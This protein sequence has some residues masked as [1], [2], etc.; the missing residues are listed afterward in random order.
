[1]GEDGRFLGG[2]WRK[3]GICGNF[4]R[5]SGRNEFREFQGKKRNWYKEEKCI[6]KKV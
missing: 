2:N 5:V 3:S 6:I 1:M 4:S